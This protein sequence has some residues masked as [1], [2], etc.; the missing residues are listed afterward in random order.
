MSC[1]STTQQT[2][3]KFN[4]IFP[5]TLSCMTTACE[6]RLPLDRLVNHVQLSRVG[7]W[8]PSLRVRNGLSTHFFATTRP[9]PPTTLRLSASRTANFL[10]CFFKLGYNVHQSRD[11]ECTK[12]HSSTRSLT[13]SL[14]PSNAV[15]RQSP[16][17]TSSIVVHL[18]QL[19]MEVLRLTRRCPSACSV[20]FVDSHYSNVS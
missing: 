16:R 11:F 17:R 9:P 3:C 10:P 8:G 14:W 13:S 15:S 7:P 1:I 5:V 20:P 6:N 19:V 12:R 4:L 2:H 18:K